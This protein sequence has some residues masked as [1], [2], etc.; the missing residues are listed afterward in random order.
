[1]NDDLRPTFPRITR[2]AFADFDEVAA[3][4]EDMQILRRTR[5]PYQAALIRA[6]LGPVALVWSSHSSPII[7]RA[8]VESHHRMFLMRP[9]GDG[10]VLVNGHALDERRLVDQRPGTDMHVATRPGGRCVRLVKILARPDELDRVSVALTG[11]RFSSGPSLC[12]LIEPD[13]R[14]LS[15]LRSL[16]ASVLAAIDGPAER[17]DAAS[18]ASVAE[19]VLSSVVVAVSS[20]LGR[21]DGHEWTRDFQARIIR[22][23]DAFVSI[24][25]GERIALSRLCV[26]AGATQR[27]LQRAFRAVYGISPNRYVKLRRL[28]LARAALLKATDGTTVV[29]IAIR[30]GFLD[31]GRFAS[32]YRG[33]FGE[34]PSV[35]L[36]R[37]RS[38]C[39]RRSGFLDLSR[40]TYRAL[41]QMGING[42]EVTLDQGRG[43]DARATPP[44]D[45]PVS[46]RAG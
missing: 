22:R 28:H 29:S 36:R 24:Y 9:D 10:A 18:V 27:Q 20:D 19:A 16:C 43:S 11:E 34:A 40:S 30:F 4:F 5:G 44:S 39:A 2:R 31:L 42:G 6:E 17:A 15:L 25:C 35:T 8:R 1:M 21:K 23:A 41:E 13:A 45:A 26:G 32:A 12:T 3:F 38:D 7:A 14:A 46:S 33:L 37:E